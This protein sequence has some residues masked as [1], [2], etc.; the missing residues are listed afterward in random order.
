[1]KTTAQKWGNSLAIRVPK[2]IAQQA[3]LKVKDDLEIEIR[4]GAIVLRPRLRRVY[5]LE[6]LVKRI[7]PRN[8]HEETDF[9]GPVGRGI[10]KSRRPYMP[11]RGDIVWMQFSPQAGHE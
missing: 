8:V 6:D 3:G 5:R 11:D 4:K 7:A 1:M 10:L 9:C 2:S